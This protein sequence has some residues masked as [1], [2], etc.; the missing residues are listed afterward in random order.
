M[1]MDYV[2]KSK[3]NIFTID[4]DMTDYK[5]ILPSWEEYS[6]NDE[7]LNYDEFQKG[8]IDNCFWKKT[9]PT[10]SEIGSNSFKEQEIRRVLKTGVWVMIK[11]EAVW[12][13]P[14]YYMALKYG[15]VGEVDLQF[16]LKRLKH[17]Y[18]KIRARKNPFCKGTLTIKGRGDG[19]TTMSMQDGL[20]ECADGNM[21][22]GQVGIQSKTRADAINPCWST[23]QVMWQS[24]PVW[25]KE[26]L[27]SDCVSGDSI[28]EKLLF[29]RNSDEQRGI[30]ARNVR[31]QYYPCVYN[32]M[33]GKHNMKK[34]ILDEVCKW[35]EALFYD[36]FTNYSKFIMPGFERRGMFDMFSSPSDVPCKSN[37]QVYELWKDS[38]MDELDENGC[39][40]SGIFRYF[41]NSL[42][43]VQG[44][45][46]KFGDANPEK[47]YDWIMK[48]RASVPK[49]KLQGEIRGFPLNE[50]EAFGSFDGKRMWSNEKG[51]KERKIY[52]MGARFKDNATREPLAVYGNLDW[53]DGIP[54]TEVVFRQ[55]DR[56][57]F[58]VFDARFCFSFLPQQKQELKKVWIDSV[59]EYR[60]APPDVV[61]NCVGIDPIDK[62]YVTGVKGFSNAA[63]VNTKFLDLFDT[64]IVNCPTGM[65]SCR[66]QHASV[67]FEDAIKF[68]VFV[69]AMGQTESINS[70]LIDYFEDR[71]Y[72]HWLLSK[73]GDRRNSVRKGDAPTG[74][75]KN[76]FL[77]EIV[78]LID[79]ATNTPVVQDEPY[80][81]QMNY[82]LELIEDVLEF[83]RNN[84]QKSDKTMAWGQ[85]LFGVVKML[86]KVTKKPSKL[87]G[88]V[89]SYLLD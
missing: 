26:A 45:Y 23:I 22:V 78:M 84:T 65:Y 83:D 18:H 41:S 20:W 47:I 17:V 49:D 66:P 8:N 77:D 7:I 35:V 38:N 2:K 1:G 42:E 14:S 70:K 61:E 63:M 36:T 27:Y 59:Q 75:G 16:R 11:E 4:F 51:L 32:A 44:A 48:T 43:G 50:E 12:I 40:R 39:T 37:D 33:D 81:L 53:K 88:Q 29:Q 31:I 24:Y 89:I 67:F 73:R 82:L 9:N 64:G 15:K 80:L 85:S 68:C 76:A 87:N 10:L 21:N 86:H 13:P 6:R 71:G 57:S 79:N 3:S 55:A 30:D 19:E 69:Q 28:A 56:N 60:L 62:R 58:D 52:L 74:G 5:D 46:D 34:C 25:L 72:M 54:D